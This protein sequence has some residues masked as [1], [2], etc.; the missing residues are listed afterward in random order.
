MPYTPDQIREIGEMHD[1][2]LER[3][4]ALTR[5]L[6]A[7]PFGYLSAPILQTWRI[8]GLL[9]LT[10]SGD[11]EGPEVDAGLPDRCAVI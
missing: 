6:F 4:S 8:A 7:H 10:L 5:R 1:E 3:E 9:F 11:N 2:W